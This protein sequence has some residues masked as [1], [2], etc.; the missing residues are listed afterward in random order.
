MHLWPVYCLQHI[1]ETAGKA[2]G[3]DARMCATGVVEAWTGG[4]SWDQVTEDCNLDDGDIARL[5]NRQAFHIA[6][7]DV[8]HVIGVLRG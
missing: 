6:C 4:S 8:L 7:Q 5:L 3:L 1:G 2:A